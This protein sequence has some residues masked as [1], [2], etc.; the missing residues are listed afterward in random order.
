M[1]TNHPQKSTYFPR[2][3]CMRMESFWFFKTKKQRALSPILSRRSHEMDCL[4][5]RWLNHWLK[6]RQSERSVNL[7]SAKTQKEKRIF[8]CFGR[9]FLSQRWIN[10]PERLM[11]GLHFMWFRLCPKMYN[12]CSI[13]TFLKKRCRS[14]KMAN[15]FE[16]KKHDVPARSHKYHIFKL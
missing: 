16:Y 4:F 14:T 6:Y 7:S 8:L 1:C 10:M 15:S 3:W 5:W 11:K 2:K 13:E 9:I 12:Y